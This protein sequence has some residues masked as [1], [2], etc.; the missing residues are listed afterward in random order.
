MLTE[1]S[2]PVSS[3]TSLDPDETSVRFHHAALEDEWG[4]PLPPD[5]IDEH[6]EHATLHLNFRHSFWKVRRDATIRAFASQMI[7]G[8][9][10]ERFEMCGQVA[11]LLRAKDDSER[12][13]IG[14][15]RCHDR[16]CEACAV[17][18]RRTVT[19]N[20]GARLAGKTLRLLTLTLKA[21]DDG[22][23]ASLTRLIRGFRRMRGE[24]FFRETQT[25]GMYFIEVTLNGT[26]RRWHPHLHVLIEGKYLP[27]EQIKQSWLAITGD[28][29]VVDIRQC[30]NSKIAASYVAKYAS[31]AV[32]SN[33]WHDRERFCEAIVAIAGQR[34][35][36]PFGTWTHLRLSRPPADD[37]EWEQVCELWRVIELSR[38]GDPWAREVVLKLT[39]HFP[40]E[41]QDLTV[42]KPID[43]G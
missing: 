32:S 33:V 21:N 24:R 4:R 13:R 14:S 17:E 20:V 30:H 25:G 38:S 40:T 23:R 8:R 7:P 2:A 12:Y 42:P 16:W 1:E 18:K 43:T 37:H 36:Q 22:L 10:R 29:Y 39:R 28:S 34:T 35:F 15:N 41:P 19:Q 11:W 5:M 27:H 9:R 31:K 26:T 6:P 3:L